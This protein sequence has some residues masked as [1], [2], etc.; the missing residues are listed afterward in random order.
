MAAPGTLPTL[1]NGQCCNL[2]QMSGDRATWEFYVLRYLD[3]IA[4]G[5]VVTGTFSS[6]ASAVVPE[7]LFPKAVSVLNNADT[8][9]LAANAARKP[10]SYIQNISAV[11]VFYNYGAAATAASS[12]LNP[13]ESLPLGS[14]N[15]VFQGDLHM[16]QAS[17]G[18]V[19]VW[20][21]SFV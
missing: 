6:G 7:A 17:G 5:L 18:A 11:P 9:V 4:N 15:F 14:G 13:G 8:I 19:N 1:T 3:A 20:I 10:G 2:M 21:V 16:F 12:V